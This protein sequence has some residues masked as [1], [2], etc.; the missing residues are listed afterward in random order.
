M[1][2]KWCVLG[3]S[4]SCAENGVETKQLI[5]QSCSERKDTALV[6]TRE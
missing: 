3:P 1:K 6:F 5:L 2:S 4:S